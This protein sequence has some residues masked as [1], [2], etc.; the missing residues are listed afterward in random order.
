MQNPIVNHELLVNTN[1][2][3]LFH[4]VKQYITLMEDINIKTGES[5]C[6][7]YMGNFCTFHSLFLKPETAL[8]W[9]RMRLLGQSKSC[10]YPL[11]IFFRWTWAVG[12]LQNCH[13]R[14]LS[15]VALGWAM[16]PVL[17]PSHQAGG[18]WSLCKSEHL[19]ESKKTTCCV[20]HYLKSVVTI[21]WRV[22]I[23]KTLRTR[24]GTYKCCVTTVVVRV[25][26]CGLTF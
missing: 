7:G 22:N 11:W 6:W 23:G 8:V 16:F 3:T 13:W 26:G 25:S 17:Y 15:G 9:W 5:V 12:Q 18:L 2:L 20:M 4:Q 21:K 1:L 19:V 14:E 24:L 10:T